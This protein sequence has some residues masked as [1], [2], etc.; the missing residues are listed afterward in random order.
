MD[1]TQKIYNMATSIILRSWI[2]FYGDMSKR[3]C[4]NHL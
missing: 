2:T 4:F 1:Q 3:K